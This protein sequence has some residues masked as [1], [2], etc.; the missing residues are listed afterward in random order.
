MACNQERAEQIGEMAGGRLGEDALAE[1]LDHV[2]S[3][4]ACS[5][6]VDL[7]ADLVAADAPAVGTAS[8]PFAPSSNRWPLALAALFLAM[9]GLWALNRGGSEE[10]RPDVSIANLT[11]LPLFRG[12]LRGELDPLAWD[13]A[14]QAYAE[15]DFS[16]AFERLAALSIGDEDPHL[17]LVSLYRGI[18]AAQLQQ[19]PEAKRDLLLAAEQGEGL[20]RDRGRWFLA[21]VHLF[22][23]ELEPA[24]A[25]LIEL[26]AED[27]DYAPNAAVQLERME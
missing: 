16:A 24:R 6:E 14:M 4:A 10:P 27:Q 19:W 15:A 3:C 20:V 23:D 1:L 17:A 22:L 8:T 9:M 26:V 12:V 25:L 13:R 5:Q 18:S 7:A 2:T 21:Q 11:P